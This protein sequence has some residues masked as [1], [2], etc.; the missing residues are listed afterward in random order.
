M[1]FQSHGPVSFTKTTLS[2]PVYA[3]EFDPYNRGYLVVGGGGGQGRSGV[4]NKIT[5]LDTSKRATLDTTAEIE[6]SSEEDSITSLATLASKDGLITLAGINSS[7]A[8]QKAGKNEHLRTFE[9]KYPKKKQPSDEK[10]DTD[11]ATAQDGSISFVGKTS[12]F[13]PATGP[14][15]ETY[16]RVLRL[17]PTYKRD[18]PNRRIGAVATGLAKQSEIVVFDAT[19]TPTTDS[20]IIARI[21]LRDNAEAADLDITELETNTFSITWATDYDV[22]EQTVMY[23]FET[24]K[25]SFSPPNPRKVYTMPLR[26]DATKPARPKYRAIR[27]LGNEDVLLLSNLPGRSGAEL[28]IVHFY[29][30]G[31]AMQVKLKGLPGHVKQAVGLDVCSLDSDKAGNKQV[32]V[33]VASHDISIPVYTLD[34]N[35]NTHTFG[36]FKRFTTLRD[37]H[38]LQ[39]TCLRFSPFHSP[40]RAPAPEQDKKGNPIPAKNPVHPGPQYIKLCS[41]SMGNTV[42]VDTFALL[43]SQ[44]ADRLSRY[45]L[46]HP[47]DEVRQRTTYGILIGFAVLVFAVLLQSVYSSD[48]FAPSFADIIPLPASWQKTLAHPAGIADSMGRK[49]WEPI[50]DAASTVSSAVPAAAS[51]ISSAVPEAASAISSA[52]PSAIASPGTKIA[53]LLDMHFA[54]P[55]GSSNDQKAV[56]VRDP[57]Q[58]KSLAVH[59]G[60]KQAYMAQDEKARH[61]HEFNEEEKKV[62]KSRLVEAGHWTVEEGETILKGVVF[63]SWAGFVGRVAGEVIREL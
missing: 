50:A 11:T 22:Y 36:K 17:S 16:Q 27:W 55:G 32:V 60:D 35:A 58:G 33:A 49:G 43:P 26:Q 5:L 23:N 47:S 39:M 13:K 20:D 46:L 38:P 7:E 42:V 2:Y 3:A 1:V 9:I 19:R 14:K 34:Y 45:V 61:W 51:S 25:A 37:V 63:S 40:V 30:S 28:S 24:K 29:P 57:G 53:D 4:A 10:Q 59:M 48:P 21:P 31:P 56:I 54:L 6:L 52:I 62:W 8:D 18:S 15:P 44:P 12:I 41:T